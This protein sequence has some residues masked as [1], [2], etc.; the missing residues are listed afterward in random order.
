MKEKIEILSKFRQGEDKDKFVTFKTMMDYE[1]ES[2]LLD[3]KGYTS[4]SRTLLRLHRGMGTYSNNQLTP[5]QQPPGLA[6]HC[7]I[8][9]P[10]VVVY[11]VTNQSPSWIAPLKYVT[12]CLQTLSESSS[13]NWARSTRTTK[14]ARVAWMRT[15]RPWPTFTRGSLGRGLPFP[16]S[17]YPREISC[18]P[19]CVPTSKRPWIVYR[20]P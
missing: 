9:R 8:A 12:Y 20:G 11:L 17:L 4:G 15:T 16:Y 6:H 13:R 5:Y 7:L 14:R 18:S 19:R 3:K 10:I 2:K 1:A